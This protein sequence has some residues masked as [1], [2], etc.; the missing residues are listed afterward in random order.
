MECTKF[1]RRRAWC[2]INDG[3]VTVELN[4]EL[5]ATSASATL[6]STR[7]EAH[8]HGTFRLIFAVF[9][10]MMRREK[11]RNIQL[12]RQALESQ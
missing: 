2:Y 10:I 11:A 5:S 12:S 1:N 6:M 9:L 3:P 8:P 4:I 7:I